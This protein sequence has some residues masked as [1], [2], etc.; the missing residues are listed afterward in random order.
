MVRAC[1][2]LV[3]APLQCSVP[4]TARMPCADNAVGDS[5]AAALAAGIVARGSL[6]SLG[7][8]SMCAFIRARTREAGPALQ[9]RR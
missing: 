8:D 1:D 3:C 9:Q 7:L 2:T 6:V 4:S 5:G